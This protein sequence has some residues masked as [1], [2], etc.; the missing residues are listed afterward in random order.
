MQEESIDIHVSSVMLAAWEP[1][2]FARN[3]RSRVP[4]VVLGTT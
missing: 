3:T 2:Y 1:L 4:A